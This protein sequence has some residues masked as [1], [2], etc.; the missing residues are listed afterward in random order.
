MLAGFGGR[1]RPCVL[2][3]QKNESSSDGGEDESM[4]L[5]GK[6]VLVTLCVREGVYNAA[7]EWM[8]TRLSNAD[9]IV[10]IPP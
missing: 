3:L 8:H 2:T 9:S 6:I 5:A 4:T 7:S 10:S 1:C